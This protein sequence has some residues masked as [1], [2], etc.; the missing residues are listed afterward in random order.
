MK[1]IDSKNKNLIEAFDEALKTNADLTIKCKDGG[2]RKYIKNQKKAG[3][4]LR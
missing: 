2:F 1:I 4:K 3:D